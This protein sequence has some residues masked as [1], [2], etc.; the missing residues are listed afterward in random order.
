MH[1]RLEEAVWEAEEAR[2]VEE[3]A[4]VVAVG[5]EGEVERVLKE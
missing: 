2:E 1:H 3:E 5:E 4:R